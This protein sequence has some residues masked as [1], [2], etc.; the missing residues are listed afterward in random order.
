MPAAAKSRTRRLPPAQR[1]QEIIESAATV[2]LASGLDAV[3]YRSVAGVLGCAPGLVHH[4]FDAVESLEA[5]AFG[6]AAGAALDATFTRVDALD[7][8]TEGLRLLLLAWVSEDQDPHARLWL[9][10]WCRATRSPKVKD[11]V[12]RTMRLGHSQVVALLTRGAD[13][14]EF[15]PHDPDAVAWQLLT[16][17][18]GVIVHVAVGVNR[19]LVDVRR[20]IARAAEKEL[21]LASEALSSVFDTVPPDA[22]GAGRSLMAARPSDDG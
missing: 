6:H 11:T 18:D 15:A 7:S 17:L 20:T 2:A 22:P 16:A 3:T 1:R 10:A 5:E 13:N 12:D 21:G 19:G 9:D 8:P 14:G 4:Y